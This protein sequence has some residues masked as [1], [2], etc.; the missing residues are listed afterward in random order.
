[1]S[2]AM[3]LAG[4]QHAPRLRLVG[5][6]SD[7]SCAGVESDQEADVQR[8]LRRAQVVRENR[9]ASQIP[10]LDAQS[11]FS[12]RIAEQL[13]GG[14]CALLAPERRRRLVAVGRRLGMS[15]FESNLV[16]AGAQEAARR[17][18]DLARPAVQARLDLVQ[19]SLHRKRLFGAV[20]AIGSVLLGAGLLMALIGWVEGG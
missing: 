11:I 18:E 6:A 10:P 14:R 2:D 9:A 20:I 16:I 8:R 19:D 12:R 17:G 3:S 15:A 7:P 4:D 5:D 13:D 1:M